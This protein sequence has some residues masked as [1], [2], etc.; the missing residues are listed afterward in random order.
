MTDIDIDSIEREVHKAEIE[1]E[2]MWRFER[3]LHIYSVMGIVISIFAGGYFI[4]TLIPYD[5]TTYQLI[6]LTREEGG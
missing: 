6:S 3:I 2:K 5:L 1:R 4:L